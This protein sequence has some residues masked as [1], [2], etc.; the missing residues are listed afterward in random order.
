MLQITLKTRVFFLSLLFLTFFLGKQTAIAAEMADVPFVPG[1]AWL[2]GSASVVIGRDVEG[3]NIIPCIMMN[4]YDN[5]F[6][7]RVSG[8]GQHILAIAIDFRQDAFQPEESYRV[9]LAI[10]KTSYEQEFAGKAFDK[11]TLILNTQDRPE[12]YYALSKGKTLRMTVG[13][14]VMDF[15][16]FGMQEGLQRME[17]CFSGKEEGEIAWR[18][19]ALVDTS[20]PVRASETKG[21]EVATFLTPMPAEQAL[22]EAAEKLQVVAPAAG[23]FGVAVIKKDTTPRRAVEQKIARQEAI[24]D[25]QPSFGKKVVRKIQDIFSTGA[26][27]IPDKGK[28]EGRWRAMSGAN[29]REVLDRWADYSDSR[30]LWLAGQD[31]PVRESMV[32][33]GTFETAVL[34]LLEQYRDEGIRPVGKMYNDSNTDQKVLLIER[35]GTY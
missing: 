35:Y 28:M 16:L 19:A 23:L 9:K 6:V 29:L 13:N 22:D 7:F 3:T 26:G 4:Q 14:S 12:L 32:V 8:G 18:E 33:Q 11:S 24:T 21:G 17:H 25:W 5:G 20:P 27:P 15:A 34:M 2:V 30:L 10:E 1:S 31:F